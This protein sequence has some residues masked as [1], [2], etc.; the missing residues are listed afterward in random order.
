MEHS[1]I[2]SGDAPTCHI[3]GSDYSRGVCI[4][5]E[6]RR[7]IGLVQRRCDTCHCLFTRDEDYVSV[8]GAESRCDDCVSQ[9][10]HETSAAIRMLG[11]RAA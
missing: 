10:I 4:Q 1:L 9:Q 7:D 8:F 3:C 2:I 6:M 11:L 5:C